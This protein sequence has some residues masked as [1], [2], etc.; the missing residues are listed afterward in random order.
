[1]T[2][3]ERLVALRPQRGLQYIPYTRRMVRS[4]VRARRRTVAVIRRQYYIT[5]AFT[6]ARKAFALNEDIAIATLICSAV[7]TFSAISIAANTAYTFLLAASI[8]SSLAMVDL[9]V[10]AGISFTVLFT[11]VVWLLALQQNMLSISLMEGATR[12]VKRSLRRTFRLGLGLATTTAAAWILIISIAL[13]PMV[14]ALLGIVTVASAIGA[15]MTATLPYLLGSA[16]FGLAWASFVSRNFTLVP[17]VLLFE[18]VP[19]WRTAFSR[20]R[21]LVRRKG[22]GFITASYLCLGST[23][24]ALYGVSLVLQYLTDINCLLFFATFSC[25]AVAAANAMLTM[26]YRKRKLART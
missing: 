4:L 9:G 7:L 17:Y 23:L 3:F 18:S 1:M 2:T 12:K 24:G 22:R 11:L 25:A 14:I 5:S 10:L 8:I 16:V 26:F 15:D 19:D 6:D 20:S 13:G 21:A